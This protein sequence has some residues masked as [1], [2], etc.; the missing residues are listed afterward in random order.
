[1]V[2]GK[3]VFKHSQGNLFTLLKQLGKDSNPFAVRRILDN[4]KVVGPSLEEK[5]SSI[6]EES[7][8][9][10]IEFPYAPLERMAGLMFE[11]PAPLE[12]MRNRGFDDET[13]MYF[14]VGYSDK[15]DMI[16][17]PMHD[18]NGMCVG[19]IGRSVSGKEFKNSRHLPKRRVPWN[20]HRAKKHGDTVVIVESAFD[21]MRVHQAGYR[22]VVA[23]LGG[24]ISDEQLHL[25]E[26]TFSKIIVMTD[27][28]EAG[29]KL[30]HTIQDRF[31]GSVFWAAYGDRELYPGDAKDA[32]DMTDDEIR[33]CLRNAVSNFEYENW[34][35]EYVQDS[36]PTRCIV[37]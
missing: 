3:R 4:H 11:Y 22:N 6:R 16:M 8:E 19:F 29:R 9:E 5:L 14:G 26:R 21:A 17:T 15:Q 23:L 31:T 32:G 35:I 28:D 24:S 34:G 27:N 12:Y 2:E 13:L 10:F 20:Y 30:G 7:A 1:M 36:G 18:P 25:L 37:L 33:Q